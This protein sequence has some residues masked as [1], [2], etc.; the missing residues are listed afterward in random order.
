MSKKT[1]ATTSVFINEGFGG[2][3]NKISTQLKKIGQSEVITDVF[4]IGALIRCQ[5]TGAFSSECTGTA[6]L[7]SIVTEKKYRTPQGI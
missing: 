4:L 5:C 1:F 6:N 2:A 7:P 3:S